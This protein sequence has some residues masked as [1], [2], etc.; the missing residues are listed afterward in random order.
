MVRPHVSAYWNQVPTEGR[1][2]HG[3]ILT[4]LAPTRKVYAKSN[5]RLH[6]VGD[7]LVNRDMATT[8]SV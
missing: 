8:L 5:G 3:K 1:A 7:T 2:P 4:H 6:A